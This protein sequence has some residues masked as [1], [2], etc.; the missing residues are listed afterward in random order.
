MVERAPTT[1]LPP[2]MVVLGYLPGKYVGNL[3]LY[4]TNRIGR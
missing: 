2:R 1:V 3:T 4:Y